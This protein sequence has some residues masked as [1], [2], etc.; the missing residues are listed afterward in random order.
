[1][2]AVGSE[3]KQKPLNTIMLHVG[4]GFQQMITMSI[5]DIIKG[6]NARTPMGA[7]TAECAY[8]ICVNS[9]LL[10]ELCTSS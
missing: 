5:V 4:R 2:Q 10:L 1:V 9:M 3:R 8:M 6:G 7:K